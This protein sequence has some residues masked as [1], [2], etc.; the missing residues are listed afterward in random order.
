MNLDLSIIIP[1]RNEEENIEETIHSI[2]KVLNNI[3]NEIIVV[4]DHSTDKTEETVK[5]ISKKITSVR[6]IRN[7]KSP[8][9]AHTLLSGFKSAKGDFVL[10]VM[11]D[12]CD[13]PQTI[14]IMFEKAQ[15]GYDMICGSRYMKKGGKCGGPKLQ[16]LFSTFV[17]KSLYYI[18][19]IPTRDVSN[20]LKMYRKSALDKIELKEKGF[21]VSM[22]AAL[23]FY[24]SGYKISE[25]PTIWYGR[26][27][28]KS[29]FRLTKTFPYIRLYFWAIIKWIF[30]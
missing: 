13:E 16:G 26:K 25:V 21:S 14:P 22:E 9:F 19:R 6:I 20:A 29:K 5:N 10:P 1:A 27:K 24:F 11:A 7:E 28:G 23:K 30:Q 18:I 2:A 8:G 4:N 17:G 3:P 15:E 12:G